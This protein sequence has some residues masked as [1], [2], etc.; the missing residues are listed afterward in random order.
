VDEW[1]TDRAGAGILLEP[2]GAV[3]SLVVVVVVH[4]QLED[5]VQSNRYMFIMLIKF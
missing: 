3:V 5:T 2:A 4:G 1:L